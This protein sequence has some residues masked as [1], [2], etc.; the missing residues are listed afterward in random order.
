MV[1]CC[2]NCGRHIGYHV[3]SDHYCRCGVYNIIRE[4]KI[5]K[6]VH[7]ELHIKP[8]AHERTSSS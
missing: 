6:F 4:G 1:E 2:G 3:H 7:K 5:T 8:K